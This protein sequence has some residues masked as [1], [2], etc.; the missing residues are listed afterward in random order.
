M[1]V[2][3]VRLE[4]VFCKLTWMSFYILVAAVRWKFRRRPAQGGTASDLGKS[5]KAGV[6]RLPGIVTGLADL[7]IVLAT[8]ERPFTKAN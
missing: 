4:W 2:Q 6:Q 7:P 3:S 1:S 8:G 5:L